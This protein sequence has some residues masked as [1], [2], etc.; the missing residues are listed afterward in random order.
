MVGI[1]SSKKAKTE[2]RFAHRQAEE[3]DEEEVDEEEER[4]QSVKK[5]KRGNNDNTPSKKKT[6]KTSSSDNN[7][8]PNKKAIK[9]KK[10]QA[11]FIK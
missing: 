9:I 8:S 5:R 7:V 1:F 3:L 2:Y 6:R 11:K 10:P 4:T